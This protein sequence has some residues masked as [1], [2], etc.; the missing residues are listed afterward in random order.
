VAYH[1]FS[2]KDVLQFLFNFQHP[3]QIVPL[4][5]L[6][7]LSSLDPPSPDRVIYGQSCSILLQYEIKCNKY[8]RRRGEYLKH[9][10]EQLTGEHLVNCYTD[11]RKMP[12]DRQTF[13]WAGPPPP[14]PPTKHGGGGGG[15]PGGGGG[16]V[17]MGI[18]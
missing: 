4:S 7:L 2:I 8:R 9:M 12:G 11:K 3:G 1:N 13:A 18:R 14:P 17:E 6:L 10:A 16:K 5:I 15:G